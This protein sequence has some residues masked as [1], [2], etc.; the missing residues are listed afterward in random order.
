MNASVS[1]IMRDQVRNQV[2]NIMAWRP[3]QEPR[4]PSTWL[5]AVLLRSLNHLA[6]TLFK[7]L[8]GHQHATRTA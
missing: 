6:D 7:G 2:P 4:Q 5:A 1:Y 3:N 8:H